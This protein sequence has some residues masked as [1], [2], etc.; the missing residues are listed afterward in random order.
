MPDAPF[1]LGGD[2]LPEGEYLIDCG[3]YTGEV[4]RIVLDD[5]AG[6]LYNDIID[7]VFPG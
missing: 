1:E 4:Q 5:A 7:R 6:T 3:G 2:S